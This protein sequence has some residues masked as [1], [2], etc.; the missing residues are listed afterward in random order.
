MALCWHECAFG[1]GPRSIV[2]GV[3]SSKAEASKA[4]LDPSDVF[5]DPAEQFF[6]I[7]DSFLLPLLGLVSF[8]I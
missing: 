8:W 7:G 4:T 3:R 6:P 2:S 1:L 5:A